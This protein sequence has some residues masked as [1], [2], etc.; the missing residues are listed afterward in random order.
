MNLELLLTQISNINNRYEENKKLS[1]EEFNIFNLLNLSTDEITHSKIIATLL[2]PKGMHG[3]DN[4]F[5]EL[6]LKCT[7]IK[8]FCIDNVVTVTE[9]FIG[10]VSKDYT[11]G[12]RI[13]IVLTNKL[14]KQIFIENKIYAEDQPNQLL[15]YNNENPNAILLYLTLSGDDPSEYSIGKTGNIKYNN[16]SY[17]EHILKWL[18]LCKREATD[19]PLLRETLTQYIVLIKELTSQ[20]RSEEMNKEFLDIILKDADNILATFIVSENIKKVKY[21]ILHH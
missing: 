3:K 7:G 6:F 8:D 18:E 14:N 2:N 4:K 20:T 21:Q 11:T 19:N 10:P 12:G 1:G 16:I 5:L 15:R 13:D 17:K 9:K